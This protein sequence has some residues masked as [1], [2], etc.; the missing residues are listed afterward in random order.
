MTRENIC[1]VIIQHVEWPADIDNKFFVRERPRKHELGVQEA[2]P[3]M[4]RSWKK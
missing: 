3:F 4:G 1:E 2:L